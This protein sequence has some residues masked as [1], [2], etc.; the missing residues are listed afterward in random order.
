MPSP[1]YDPDIAGLRLLAHPLRLRLLSLLTAQAMSAAESARELGE[2]QANVSYHLR[3]L[4]EGGLLE[5]AERVRVS[6]GLARRYRHDPSSGP[7]ALAAQAGAPGGH[8]EAAA[9]MAAELRRRA[10][11]VHPDGP[12]HLTDAEVWIDP[13]EWR[14]LIR[15]V[16]DAAD[17]LHAAARPPHTPGTIPTGTTLVMFAL[18][19]AAPADGDGGGVPDGHE[20]R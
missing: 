20:D 7:P 2:T 17:R 12:S 8:R 16:A 15:A 1:S 4:H 11:L 19:A 14:S 9:A 18:A 5:I 3:R 6:G 10:G 13:A